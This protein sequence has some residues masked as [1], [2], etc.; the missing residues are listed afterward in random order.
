MTEQKLD[1]VIIDKSDTPTDVVLLELTVPWDSDANFK[2]ALDR[3]TARYERLAG[4]L[5]DRDLTC[6]NLPLEI[7]LQPRGA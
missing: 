2:A 5:R 6:L 1:L 4:D 7:G 3:K